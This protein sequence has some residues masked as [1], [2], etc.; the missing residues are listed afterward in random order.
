VKVTERLNFGD[1]L[2]SAVSKARFLVIETFDAVGMP[3]VDGVATCRGERQPCSSAASSIS[4]SGLRG[5]WHYVDA[6]SGLR[7]LCIQPGRGVLSY[8]GRLLTPLRVLSGRP[9]A[10]VTSAVN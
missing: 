5:G 9:L 6:V 3:S 8:D 10:A 7:L 1:V 4:E 2:C